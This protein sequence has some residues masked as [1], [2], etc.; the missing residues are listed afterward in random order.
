MHFAFSARKFSSVLETQRNFGQFLGLKY[1][2]I[3]T[4]RGLS[5]GVRHVT[6]IP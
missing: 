3:T 2:Y 5:V 1:I 4:E 6:S